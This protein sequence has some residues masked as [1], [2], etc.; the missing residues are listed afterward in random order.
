MIRLRECVKNM[1]GYVPG[2]PARDAESVKLNQNENRYPPS[3]KVL[4]AAAEAAKGLALYPESTS[5]ELRKAAAKVCGTMPGRVMAANGSDEMLRIFFQAFCDPG[6]EV[7]AFYPSYTYYATLAAMQ[8]VRY[9]LIE[10]TEQFLLPEKLD[11][12]NAKLVFLPNPN[13]PTGTLFP[14]SEIRRLVESAPDCMVV[15]DEAYIAFAPSGSDSIHLIDE[16]PNIAVTR[17]L[18]KSHSLAG[19][20]VGLGFAREEVLAEL[21]KVRDYYN[22]DRVAAA[23][24]AAALL[25]EEWLA[26]TSGRIVASRDEMIKKLLGLGLK[27]YPSH[28]NFFLLDCRTP[29]EAERLFKGLG[30][31]NVLVRYFNSRRLDS[32]L[33]VSVGTDADMTRLWNALTALIH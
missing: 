32:C 19:L 18:S 33:R 17:T 21:E 29:A 26:D 1:Q 25:D 9:R 31:Q 16:Y 30:E 22:L 23:A 28:A 3:S 13:A 10:F 6:D 15:I 12:G 4:A 27:V 14:E 5:L 8:D 11:I 7:A 20:R 2:A 24:G